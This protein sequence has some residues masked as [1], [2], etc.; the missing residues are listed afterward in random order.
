[1]VPVRFTGTGRG[2]A[3]L[4]HGVAAGVPRGGAA[5][6]GA[7]SLPRAVSTGLV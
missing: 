7:G 5:S 4:R 2:A 3:R 6:E 1:M